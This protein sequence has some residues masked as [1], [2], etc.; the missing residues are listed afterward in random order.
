MCELFGVTSRNKLEL[1]ELLLKFF[2]HGIEH[3]NGWGMAFF[4]GN[5]VSL[6]KQPEASHKSKYLR[7]RLQFK[8]ESDKMIAHI[9]LATRGT[10]NYENTHP[11]VMRDNSDRTW[12]LAH[13]GTIFDCD[14]LNPFV[15]SQ[16]GQTDSERILGYIISRVNTEI[17]EKKELSGQE[18]FWLID[19]IL[20]EITP[21]NKVNLLLYDGELMYVH[22]N[23][24]NSLY[25]CRKGEAVVISTKPLD[26]HVW[27][28][29]PM[30]TLI[31]YQDGKQIYTGTKHKNEFF[32]T[33]EKMHL[34]FLDFANL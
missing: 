22:T 27:E 6:E 8:V 12:T 23:Y 9:R 11:F 33:E 34:L 18:R 5:A 31:A 20:C 19:E 2:S 15:H 28:P 25:T 3:P 17:E 4:Y 29:V 32:E 7:Q 16:Q 1:N 21:E 30:N 26:C 13:N 24:Q 14:L 10:L